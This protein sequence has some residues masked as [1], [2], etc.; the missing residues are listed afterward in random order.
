[1]DI[2]KSLAQAIADSMDY[3]GTDLRCSPEVN[4]D[5]F[6]VTE[7]VDNG[8]IEV[9][10]NAGY[11]DSHMFLYAFHKLLQSGAVTVTVNDDAPAANIDYL[12]KLSKGMK[13]DK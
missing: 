5:L 11:L 12:D 3:R 7:E 1:M 4:M 13:Y 9:Y 10:M 8:N 2:N 6:N